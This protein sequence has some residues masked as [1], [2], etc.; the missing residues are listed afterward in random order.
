M[1]RGTPDFFG[2]QS[3]TQYG[4]LKMEIGSVSAD[5]N[6]TTSILSI[7]GKGMIAGGVIGCTDSLSPSDV[8][9][10]VLIDGVSIGYWSLEPSFWY[11]NA[12][13]KHF[14]VFLERVDRTLINIILGVRHGTTF[15]DSFE[16]TVTLGAGLLATHWTR[17]VGYYL[18]E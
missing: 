2:Q 8:S 12:A 7:S 6:D 11:T 13:L 14:P 17:T 5:T 3:F 4:S 1:A 10:R 9:V 18:V 15:A 16:I